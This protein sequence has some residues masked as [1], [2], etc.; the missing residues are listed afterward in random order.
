MI[1]RRW[2]CVAIGGRL[3]SRRAV[4]LAAQRPAAGL[5]IR[6]AAFDTIRTAAGRSLSIRERPLAGHHA[7]AGRP[8]VV[9]GV[10]RARRED[11]RDIR[12]I[13]EELAAAAEPPRRDRRAAGR[14]PL[15]EH[16]RTR[17]RSKRAATPLEPELRAI[18]AMDS[19]RALAERAGPAVGHDDGRAVFRDRGPGPAQRRP[20][21][22][23]TS[24][25][26]RPA[27]RTRQLPRRRS[28]R[29]RRFATEY[30][31]YLT[32]I[33]TLVGRADPRAMPRRCSRWKS[34]SRA[35]TPRSATAAPAR[36]LLSAVADERRVP[37]LRLAGVGPAAGHR[38]VAGVV[39]VQP[40]FF[41]SVRGARAEAA[42]RH[43]ARVAGRRGTSRRCRRTSTRTS[44]TRASISSDVSH[45]PARGDSAMEAR[46][47]G[48]S[49]RCLAT[50]SAA[51]TWSVTFRASSRTR[52]ERIVESGGA[53]VSNSRCSRRRG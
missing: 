45:G 30:R 49:T 10:D 42:A 15:R 19:V 2:R 27:A 1:A 13:I 20:I 36:R 22:W 46:R 18:D 14:G 33:F 7:D 35:R 39:V 11:Q 26:G 32:R 53:R 6:R 34:S 3:V 47:V 12:A 50:R 23:C 43:L 51:S 38:S 29:A 17:P 4:S 44:A 37:R 21:V 52:V 40:E 16:A 41:R 5:R 48:W 28:A 31:R 25:A 8:R 9:H 24:V